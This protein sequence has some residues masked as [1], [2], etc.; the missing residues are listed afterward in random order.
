LGWVGGQLWVVGGV[1]P[2]AP[3]RPV[4]NQYMYNVTNINKDLTVPIPLF[5]NATAFTDPD[6]IVRRP[7][8]NFLQQATTLDQ[9]GRPFMT[10]ANAT[11]TD[12]ASVSY[13]DEV[14]SLSFQICN[15]GSQTLTAPY[16]VTYY[17]DTYHGP[18][19]RTETVNTSLSPGSCTTIQTIFFSDELSPYPD[20]ENIVI[21]LNDNGTGVA[22][23]GGQ[24][25]ECDTTDNFVFLP[26]CPVTRDTVTADICVGEPYQDENFSIGTSETETP[27]TKYYSRTFQTEGCDSIV[28]LRLRVHPKYEAQFTETIPEGTSYDNHG[29]FLNESLM[30]GGTRIDTSISFQSVYGCDSVI[31]VTIQVAATDVRLYLP[32]AITPSKSDGL[33]DGFFLPERMQDQIA[34]FEIMIFNRWGEMVFYS[35]DKNFCWRGEYKGKT[36]YD[37][38]YQYVIHYSNH[39][40]KK[41]TVKGTITVL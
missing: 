7:F 28:V 33:N 6:G 31:Y 34:D 9:Y 21:A 36:F 4:W 15:T 27:C 8:N 20:I 18:I 14:Y 32:N 17:V 2:W 35:T 37:N 24:Q 13:Q 16:H 10:L 25:T 19:L 30:E 1:H 38:V 23:N 29:I 41:F 22:Q 40:G 11:A 26:P 12:S 3:A 5:D 39:F